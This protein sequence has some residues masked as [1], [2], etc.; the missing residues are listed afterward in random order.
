MDTDIYIFNIPEVI[1]AKREQAWVLSQYLTRDLVIYTVK[2]CFLN[3]QYY[4]AETKRNKL[5]NVKML[6]GRIQKNQLTL[7]INSKK[8]VLFIYQLLL[9]RH[10]Y[11]IHRRY[12]RYKEIKRMR[13][14]VHCCGS[15]RIRIR[16]DPAQP[17]PALPRRASELLMYQF[18]NPVRCAL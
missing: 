4:K 12:I 6:V 5:L 13:V 17:N 3:I 2:K 7:V 1:D 9:A 8:N 10:M 15:G 18:R 11:V 14:A 16:T